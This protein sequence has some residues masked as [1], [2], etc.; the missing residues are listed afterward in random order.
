M[1]YSLPGLLGA[2]L[3]TV[4]GVINYVVIIGFV[5]RRL[6]ARATARSNEE[7]AELAHE[8]SWVRQLVLAAVIVIF[9]TIG[10]WFGQ[11]IGG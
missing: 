9:A 3:G 1:D 10:Y 7:R 6:Q 5:M 4:L 2:F 11:T 8:M